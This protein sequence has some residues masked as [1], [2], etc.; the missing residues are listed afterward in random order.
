MAERE[1]IYQPLLSPDTIRIM[2]LYPAPAYSALIEF[3]FLYVERPSLLRDPH[4]MLYD[5][6]SY[7]WR[8]PHFTHTIRNRE[9]GADVR[10]TAPVDTMLRFFRN[11]INPQY[12]WVDAICLNQKNEDEKSVQV[13]LMA[14]IY[15]QARKVR[16]WFGESDENAARVFAFLRTITCLARL[17]TITPETIRETVA[18]VFGTESCLT[19]EAVLS[20]RWFTRRW[21]LQE[22][23]LNPNTILHCGKYKIAWNIFT[24]GLNLLQGFTGVINL[25]TSAGAS[26][27]LTTGLRDNSGD[28][29]Q[30]LWDYH[31]AECSNPHDRIYALYGLLSGIG[32]SS[33]SNHLTADYSLEWSQ[34][35]QNVAE[36]QIRNRRLRE[37]LDHV[38]SFGSLWEVNSSLP[39][40]VPNWSETRR[41]TIENSTLR[42]EEFTIK[43][44]KHKSL[45]G[46]EVY[47]TVPTKIIE[48]G[49]PLPTD[50]SRRDLACLIN[51]EMSKCWRC[52]FAQFDNELP[53]ASNL[54]KFMNVMNESRERPF[55]LWDFM[56]ETH[57][58]N[59]FKFMDI[60]VAGLEWFVDKS[61]HSEIRSIYQFIARSRDGS[62]AGNSLIVGKGP[63][64]GIPYDYNSNINS[65]ILIAAWLRALGLEDELLPHKELS[66]ASEYDYFATIVSVLS[67]YQAFYDPS[68]FKSKNTFPVE[69]EELPQIFDRAK[70]MQ[71]RIIEFYSEYE[72]LRDF[73][74]PIYVPGV[75]KM[76]RYR[77]LVQIQNPYGGASTATKVGP[78]KG[79]AGDVIVHPKFAPIT[80]VLRSDKSYGSDEIYRL[81]GAAVGI[82]EWHQARS[83]EVFYFVVFGCLYLLVWIQ[84]SPTCP[85]GTHGVQNSACADVNIWN[86][87]ENDR[88]LLE[89]WETDRR[90]GREDRREDGRENGREDGR[91]DGKE[92]GREDG[93]ED[94][95]GVVTDSGP[96]AWGG[97]PFGPL[98]KS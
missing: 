52:N 43:I 85:L 61:S 15:G 30:N 47:G 77:R 97:T 39:S 73:I 12:L 17:S 46:I 60:L 11:E 64:Y 5:A 54:S 7:V 26:L 65:T 13:P 78:L 18:E 23:S 84:S 1:T 33:Q 83:R 72:A 58:H 89:R 63:G 32:T 40:W 41:S 6:V 76:L 35:Y 37:L 79:Q 94:G 44:S 16:I 96:M 87:N 98:F 28:L 42:W 53:V 81:V 10:I 27:S 49:E 70:I 24:Q 68:V 31:T 8:E 48:A 34:V 57:P 71:S 59:L 21:V 80:L 51:R 22:A 45:K 55:V 95:K 90:D 75:E 9:I 69:H 36:V 56:R 67:N 91:E 14:E 3:D 20:N 74:S 82:A 66:A 29:L 2:R 92:D 4:A 19:L 93:R 25:S 86:G 38:F 88:S 50:F 62:S